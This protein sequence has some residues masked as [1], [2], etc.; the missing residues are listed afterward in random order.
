MNIQ[1]CLNFGMGVTIITVFCFCSVLIQLYW[2][3]SGEKV[4][5]QLPLGQPMLGVVLPLIADEMEHTV[6][7]LQR[8]PTKCSAV[9]S[10]RVDIIFYFAEEF[11]LRLDRLLRNAS[12][13][14][15]CFKRTKVVSANLHL[16]VRFVLMQY[17]A[18][19]HYTD[20]VV[21]MVLFRI[22]T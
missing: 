5:Q 4:W 9:T 20:G 18:Y 13:S 6:K 11:P 14:T 7:S 19:Y 8:W 21:S 15:S 1:T 22:L 17:R 12:V 3:R 10:S 16:R 2:I